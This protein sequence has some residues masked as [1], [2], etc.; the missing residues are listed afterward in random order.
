M[1]NLRLPSRSPVVSLRPRSA[2]S[3]GQRLV[4]GSGVSGYPGRSQYMVWLRDQSVTRDS[5]RFMFK[6]GLHPSPGSKSKW[7]QVRAQTWPASEVC[8]CGMKTATGVALGQ[9]LTSEPGEAKSGDAVTTK[10]PALS[11]R[12]LVEG[13]ISSLHLPCQTWQ[14]WA[15]Q[16][17]AFP[18]FQQLGGLS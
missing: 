4:V 1:T 11:S 10:L 14:V 16:P 5:S 6:S 13:H 17:K 18:L 15:T 12:M 8:V 3:L 9:S 2:V 7:A